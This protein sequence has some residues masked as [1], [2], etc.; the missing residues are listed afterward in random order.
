MDNSK[1]PNLTWRGMPL[2]CHDLDDENPNWTCVYCGKVNPDCALV[3][4]QGEWDG[5]G[6]SR[7]VEEEP[8]RGTL[9]L[10]N[11]GWE[12]ALSPRQ[13]SAPVDFHADFYPE[14]TMT[15]IH[16]PGKLAEDFKLELGT[17][18]LAAYQRTIKG[19]LSSC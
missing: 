15:V 5:C 8:P 12:H 18:I 1:H 6:A 16:H 13:P 3:C 19:V 10:S 2:I 14:P 11:E 17:R 9:Q 7:S 4:G